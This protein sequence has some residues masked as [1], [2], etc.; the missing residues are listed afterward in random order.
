MRQ[1]RE[2]IG[3]LMADFATRDGR[4][5]QATGD[6]LWRVLSRE[7]DGTEQAHT[8]TTDAIRALMARG[9]VVML[10][11]VRKRRRS[12]L[13]GLLEHSMG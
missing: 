12:N 7:P 3:R 6:H 9:V 1:P 2:Q 4:R 11:K 5:A 8:V 10:P 13:R